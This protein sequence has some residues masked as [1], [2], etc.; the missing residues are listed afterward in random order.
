MQPVVETLSGLERRIE[1]SIPV[2]EVEKQVQSQLKRIARTAKAQG[3]RPGKVPMS[4]VERN[5]GP[6]VRYEVMNELI[7]NALDKVIKDAELRVA[8]TPALEPKTEDV[9]EDTM[10]F[11]ATFEVYPEIELPDFSALEVTR[12]TVQVGEP[13]IQKTLDILRRQ[14]ANYVAD[15]QRVA[16]KDDRVT[17]DF[18]GTIE[19]E[20]FEGGSAQDYPFVLGH[21]RMLPQFEEAVTGLK[22]GENKTFELDFPADYGSPEVA[23]KKAEFTVTVKEVAAPELPEIDADFARSLGQA[24]GDV[25]ALMADI[26][27]NVQREAEAR[28]KNRTKASV[29]EALAGVCEFDIP[30]ALVES[31]TQERMKAIRAEF[32]QRGVPNPESIDIPADTL[33]PEAERRVRLGLLVNKL[34]ESADLSAK[35]E[36]IKARIEE[37][38]QS[39]EQPEQVVS[40]YLSNQQMRAEV[41]SFVLEDNVVEHVV[42]LAK[43]NEEAVDFDTLMGAK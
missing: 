5:H 15:E 1:L 13:E 22:A 9:P 42:N 26:S 3:F 12:S 28:A 11:F 37:F 14:R 20:P 31:E 40:Y 10:A 7:G 4:M 21:G 23:G 32:K 16:A 29:M 33:R 30:K 36:Q 43:V 25:T 6:A 2:A 8:G 39:Y 17:I 35:P 27:K 38:A 19:G 41:E 24:E 18:A 34:I